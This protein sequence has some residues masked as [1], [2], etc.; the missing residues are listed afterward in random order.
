MNAA[1]V[2]TALFNGAWQGAVLCFAAYAAFQM[3][4]RLNATTMFAVWSALL[5]IAL[6][7]PAL[8]YVFAA[9]PYTVRVAQ[10]VRVHAYAST[11]ASRVRN[12]HS[13]AVSRASFTP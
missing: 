4:R 9:R 11:P 13:A 3:L 5:V 1:L 12:V 10:P 2:L 8:N 6:A 7:L